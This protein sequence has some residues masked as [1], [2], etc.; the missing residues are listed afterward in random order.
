MNPSLVELAKRSAPP[1]ANLNSIL[2]PLAAGGRDGHGEDMSSER[3]LISRLEEAIPAAR[4]ALDAAERRLLQ[5]K[6]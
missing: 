1:I 5:L 3:D 2:L 4:C 6:K